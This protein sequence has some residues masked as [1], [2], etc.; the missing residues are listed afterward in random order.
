MAFLLSVAWSAWPTAALVV[1]FIAGF[2]ISVQFIIYG[3]HCVVICIIEISR[4]VCK[5]LKWC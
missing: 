2:L 3:L 5:G 4:R 1:R